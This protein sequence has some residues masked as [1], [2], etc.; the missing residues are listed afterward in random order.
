MKPKH[1]ALLLGGV[2]I[3]AVIAALVLPIRSSGPTLYIGTAQSETNWPF[4]YIIARSRV[5]RNGI[6]WRGRVERRT[7]RG[8]EHLE[9][10]DLYEQQ[11]KG[12]LA[13]RTRL[14]ETG[15]EFPQSWHLLLKNTPE[16]FLGSL[17]CDGWPGNR[18]VALSFMGLGPI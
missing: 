5:V 4:R 9:E 11:T 3:A 17:T 16:G 2:A 15:R 7:D 13:F 12:T 14:D 6:T 10:I 18:A 8:W 1:L